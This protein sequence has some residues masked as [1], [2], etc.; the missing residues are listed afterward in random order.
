M[1][2]AVAA[3][4]MRMGGAERVLTPLGEC[5]FFN[6]LELRIF[7]REITAAQA[8]I[9]SARFVE[10]L[11]ALPTQLFD[12]ATA[13]SRKTTATL[14][15]RTIDLLHVAA[16]LELGAQYLYS[17]DERQRKPARMVGLKLNPIA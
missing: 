12:R 2:S 3:R 15:T 13:L 11:H 4:S 17:F 16:A 8:R 9:S 6:A 10:A 1:N 5:E 14:G 7:R